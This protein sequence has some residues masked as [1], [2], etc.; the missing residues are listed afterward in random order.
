MPIKEQRA[1]TGQEEQVTNDGQP[2]ISIS[3]KP[4]IADLLKSLRGTRTLRQVETETGVSNA[5]LCNIELGMK[6]PGL[7]T[8]SKLASYYQV[9]LHDLLQVMAMPF[10]KTPDPQKGSVADIQR[11]YA[12][13]IEDPVFSQY[14]K[15]AEAMPIDAQRFV[16][17]MYEHYTG[18]RLI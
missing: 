6:R 18:K 7:K 3:E 9:P 16:V 8:L 5:Y 11:G 14:Q 10:E 2:E 12:Y 1:E 17:Q 13:V 15:P 4:P